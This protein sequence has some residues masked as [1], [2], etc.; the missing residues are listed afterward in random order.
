[1]SA[2]MLE[3]GAMS[4]A[5]GDALIFCP[6]M[7]ITAEEIGAMF[8]PVEAALDETLAAARTEGNAA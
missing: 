5:V 6:P 2:E 3:R 7:I 4:R 1:M 8:A